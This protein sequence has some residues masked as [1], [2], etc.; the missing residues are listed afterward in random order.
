MAQATRLEPSHVTFLHNH[1][2]MLPRSEWVMVREGPLT[3]RPRY[4][5][6]DPEVLHY[7]G[8]VQSLYPRGR[9]IR[10]HSR[11]LQNFL[12][13]N[14]SDHSGGCGSTA[15]YPS[16]APARSRIHR[17]LPAWLQGCTILHMLVGAL[18]ARLFSER[19]SSPSRC[20]MLLEVDRKH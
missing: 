16:L 2:H 5:I 8:V 7:L 12:Q 3:G 14:H 17:R 19:A 6:R 18:K 13:T 4:P 20:V 1:H 9:W 15:A 10:E 11:R